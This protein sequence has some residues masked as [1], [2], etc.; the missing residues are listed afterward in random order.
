MGSQLV[1]GD[2]GS[3]RFRS[4]RFT[5]SDQRSDEPVNARLDLPGWGAIVVDQN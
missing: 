5:A 4:Q 3:E 1:T 2:G